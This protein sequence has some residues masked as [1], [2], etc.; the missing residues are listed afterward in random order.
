V[1]GRS[2]VL[3]LDKRCTF[4]CDRPTV[5]GHCLNVLTLCRLLSDTALMR[6]GVEVEIEDRLPILRYK[7]CAVDIREIQRFRTRAPLPAS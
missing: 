3:C 6:F 2:P 5:T 4:T 7:A 1:P